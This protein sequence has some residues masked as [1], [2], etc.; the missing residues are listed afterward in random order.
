MP[1]LNLIIADMDERYARGLSDYINSN[2]SSAFLVSC[3]TKPDALKRYLLQ[4][5]QADVLLISPD[6]YDVSAGCL[7]AKLKVLLSNGALG[8]EYPECQVLSKYST[9]ERLLGEVVHLYS[10]LNHYEGRLSPYSKGTELIGVYSPAGGSGKTTIATA[11]AKECASMGMASF[12][13]SF[14]SLQST[15]LFYSSGGKRNLS[16][17]FY[18]LKERSRNLSFRLEGIKNTDNNCGVQYFN[19]PESPLELDELGTDELEQL[20]LGMKAMA[21]YDYI[22]ID[23]SSAF[24]SKNCKILS[25]CD[26]IILINLQ[27]PIAMHK[28]GILR[29]ELMKFNG[30]E[31]A[32][33]SDKLINVINKCRGKHIIEPE[34]NEEPDS[35]DH[36]IPEYSNAFIDEEGRMI[37]NDETFDKAVNRLMRKL[38]G[39]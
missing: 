24:D 31:N 10:N 16:Y 6:F 9:G 11:L 18:Y 27:D 29:S 14:E 4:Q 15:H 2:H 13:L 35:E 8:R 23:M 38:S 32:C 17:V 25:L 7:S 3:F 33:I 12:Y 34:G 26:S 39:E 21:F 22:F 1:K 20:L 28:S 30:S 37:I 19:P 36:I 5:Y